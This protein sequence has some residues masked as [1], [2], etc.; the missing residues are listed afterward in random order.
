MR[1]CGMWPLSCSMWVLVP[2]WDWT[3]DLTCNREVGVLATGPQ[4]KSLYL[5]ILKTHPLF[6]QCYLLSIFLLLF[7]LVLPILLLRLLFSCLSLKC[8]CLPRHLSLA[9]FFLYIVFLSDLLAQFLNYCVRLVIHISIARQVFLSE[10][11]MYPL[12]SYWSPAFR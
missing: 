7:W 10:L 12:I 3:R 11:Q 9:S 1:D 2:S 5:P 4:G 6:V 8:Q